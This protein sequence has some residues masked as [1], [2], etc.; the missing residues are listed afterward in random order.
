M[1][2]D[3]SWMLE[4]EEEALESAK[5]IDTPKILRRKR[6]ARNLAAIKEEQIAQFLTSLPAPGE[7]LH[8]VSN[9]RWDYWSFV[10]TVLRYLDRPA[11]FWGSTWTMNRNNVL[12]L[13]ALYDSGKLTR[14]SILTGTYFK[15]RES[16][17][18]ATLIEGLQARRQRYR[19]FQ[20]HAKVMLFEAPPD[21]IVIEGSANFTANP[22]LEQNVMVNDENLFRFHAEWMEEMFK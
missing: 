9:G 18:A 11:A 16:S 15:R 10:P 13:F 22:R 3:L 19:A 7:S 5:N 6:R 12:E 8:I 1:A 21:F 2:D 20:N 4:L 14:I 17:V